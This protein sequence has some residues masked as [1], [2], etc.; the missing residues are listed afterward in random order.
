M[1]LDPG[2]PGPSA[3]S[4]P[5]PPAVAQSSTAGQLPGHPE[6]SA[7]LE[8]LAHDLPDLPLADHPDRYVAVLE[9]LHDVLD[10]TQPR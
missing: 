10:G 9:L 2:Q 5:R 8:A 3:A 6:V 4:A 7:A 1:T